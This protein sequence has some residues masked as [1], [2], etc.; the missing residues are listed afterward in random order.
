MPPKRSSV[1]GRAVAVEVEACPPDRGDALV[2]QQLG[3]P[4]DAA[5][6]LVGV[7]AE[8][9][10][11][12]LVAGGELERGGPRRRARADGEDLRHARLTGAPDGAV[13]V[14]AHVQVR[15]GVDHDPVIRASSSSATP[16]S[17][18]V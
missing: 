11:D 14:V 18:F 16:G 9:R 10:P 5:A 13:G 12:A 8:D 17:S 6:R 1:P 4:V 3:Q 7:N 2:R 15:V